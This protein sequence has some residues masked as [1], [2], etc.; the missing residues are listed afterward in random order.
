MLASE[1]D[2][3]ERLSAPV[4][5]TEEEIALVQLQRLS[6]SSSASDSATEPF[7]CGVILGGYDRDGPQLYM[8]EPSGISY[9]MLLKMHQKLMVE[10][11]RRLQPSEWRSREK[12]TSALDQLHEVEKEVKS[13]RTITQ[14]MILTRDEMEEVV[15]KRCW[16]ARCGSLCV[17]YGIHAEIAGARHEYYG[18]FVFDGEIM[19][20]ES[21]NLTAENSYK[22]VADAD[23]SDDN[24]TKPNSIEEIKEVAPTTDGKVHRRS[25]SDPIQ[26]I[27]PVDS[28]PAPSVGMTGHATNS[29]S[30]PPWKEELGCLVQGGVP[31]SL[32]GEVTNNS[33]FIGLSLSRIPL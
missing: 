7:C 10:V 11:V 16:L 24:K 9:R 21:T 23:N 1:G 18:Q 33:A 6:S 2:R 8:V 25:E 17:R 15:L 31:M 14:R 19:N 12:A 5:T 29:E 28:T 26:D 13:L 27:I 22:N 20:D 32:R 30:L 3:G 4:G